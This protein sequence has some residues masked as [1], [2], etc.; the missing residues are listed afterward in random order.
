VQNT[1]LNPWNEAAGSKFGAIVIVDTN[2]QRTIA[3]T[4]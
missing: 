2:D 1:D 4:Q 3:V